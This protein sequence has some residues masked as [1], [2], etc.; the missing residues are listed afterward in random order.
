MR[1]SIKKIAASLLAA[2]MV[3]GSCMTAFA[4]EETPAAD[5]IQDIVEEGQVIYSIGS[6]MAP[7]AWDPINVAN[8]MTETEWPGVY[9]IDINV[10][11]AVD[12]EGNEA[13]LWTHRFGII[14]TDYDTT[15]AWN[16]L[17]LGAPE[18]TPT[19]T[20]GTSN[21]LTN[22]RVALAEEAR[23]VTLYFD[24][25]TYAITLK[26]AEG[27]PVDYTISWFGNDDD[28][29][30]YTPADLSALSVDE[31]KAALVTEDRLADIEACGVTTMP[32]FVELEA[33]LVAKLA[34]APEEPSTEEPST[35]EATTT[36]K[37]EEATTTKKAEEATT[38]AKAAETTTS[39]KQSPQTGDVA[40]VALMVVLFSAVA[41]VAV[42]AKKREA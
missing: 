35:E 32:N 30:Y 16:R 31:Y 25:A 23:V 15:A 34:A 39:K 29:I 36:K 28:E 5:T 38:T 18:V 6:A 10:P 12:E 41:V 3:L 9:K 1:K 7:V 8:A 22:I 17:L 33:A 14:H 11:A 26:D 24:S 4:E 42:A 40:P 21:C 27:N 37:V 2:T 20:G 19:V 13:G